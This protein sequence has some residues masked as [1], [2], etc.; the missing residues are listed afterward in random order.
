MRAPGGTPTVA[1]GDK[2][3][4]VTGHQ[5]LSSVAVRRSAAGVPSAQLSV[6]CAGLTLKCRDRHQGL[7]TATVGSG[8]AAWRSA[9][10]SIGGCVTNGLHI[11]NACMRSVG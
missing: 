3:L 9:A 7:H 4:P 5:R 8:S 10:G 2:P 6:G 1:A 11:M